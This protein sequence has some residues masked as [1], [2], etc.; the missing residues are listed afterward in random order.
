MPNSK[1]VKERK[2]PTKQPKSIFEK[3]EDYKKNNFDKSD[4]PLGVFDQYL[5]YKAKKRWN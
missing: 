5:K 4:P 2:K 1:T 3:F